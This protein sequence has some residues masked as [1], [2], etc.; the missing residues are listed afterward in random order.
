MQV[1]KQHFDTVKGQKHALQVRGRNEA[2]S[3]AEARH[4]QAAVLR[5]LEYEVNRDILS[6]VKL[7][8]GEGGENA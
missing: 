1:K 8:K 4:R 7:V 2:Q 5:D 3:I 6:K